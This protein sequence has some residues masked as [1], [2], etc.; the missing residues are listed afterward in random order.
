MRQ[1][2]TFPSGMFTAS[3][4]LFPLHSEG[5]EGGERRTIVVTSQLGTCGHDVI[6]TEKKSYVNEIKY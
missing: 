4:L 1:S 3:E 2:E 6:K 5:G